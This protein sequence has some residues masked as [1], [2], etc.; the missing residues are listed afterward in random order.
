MATVL[1]RPTEPVAP[2]KTTFTLE[3]TSVHWLA[4][5]PQA[6]HTMNVGNLLFPTGER[7]FNDSLRNALPYVTDERLRKEIRGFLGQEVTHANE[8]ERCVVRMREHGI[9][10]DRELEWFERFRRGLNRRVSRLPEPLRRQAVLQMLAVTAAAEHFTA[11][12]AGY[13]LAENSWTDAGVEPDVQHLWL[14]HAAEEIEHRHVA[15]DVYAHVGGGYLRRSLSMV[16]LALL[17]P[18]IWPLLTNEIMRRDP[19][20]RGRWSWR[21]HLASARRGLVFSLPRA[22]WDVRL[23][24]KP[25]HHPSDLPGSLEMA[26]RYLDEA[27]AVDGHRGSKRRTAQDIGGGSAEVPG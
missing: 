18:V 9:G 20:A 19:A 1:T 6:T 15:F 3:H 24:F 17:M 22:L 14:W 2:R 16:P 25:G 5:D 23:Y 12:L 27:P 8:H 10:F 13:V 26:L 11:S 7:F 4:G 21:R